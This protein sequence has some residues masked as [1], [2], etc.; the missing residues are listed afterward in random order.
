M[1]QERAYDVCCVL[2]FQSAVLGLHL[3]TG[4]SLNDLTIIYFYW[5]EP[6]RK[7]MACVAELKSHLVKQLQVSCRPRHPSQFHHLTREK[8]IRPI[9]LPPF[10]CDENHTIGN[11]HFLVC[12]YDDPYPIFGAESLAC[13]SQSSERALWN[14]REQP[15]MSPCLLQH[16]MHTHLVV[17]PC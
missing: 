9:S 4:R 10:V 15:G 8:A 12:D 16:T 7:L 2:L 6:K 13:S 11:V 1:W 5:S 17:P 14:P 3:K